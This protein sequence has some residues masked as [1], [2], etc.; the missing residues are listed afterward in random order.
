MQCTHAGVMSIEECPYCNKPRMTLLGECLDALSAYSYLDERRNKCEECKD[1]LEQAAEA[2][3]YCFPFADDA[4]LKMRAA[5]AR[6][7]AERV[8]SP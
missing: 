8:N 6:A 2:C 1:N 7:Q 3:E 5:L 4:R